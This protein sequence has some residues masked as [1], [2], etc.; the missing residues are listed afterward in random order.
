MKKAKLIKKDSLAQ[1][2]LL[3]QARKARK[4]RERKAIPKQSPL[5]ITTEWL[6]K[7][8]EEGPSARESF[9]AL[10]GKPGPQSA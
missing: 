2:E 10:F 3:T 7:S 8:R 1:A 4:A 5:E 9:A 6:K